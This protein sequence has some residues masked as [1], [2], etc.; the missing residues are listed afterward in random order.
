MADEK[1]PTPEPETAEATLNRQPTH[2]WNM[3][4]G[5]E[6]MR[7]ARQGHTNEFICDYLKGTEAAQIS[8]SALKR[9]YQT[10][11]SLGR[12]SGVMFASSKLMQ[13]IKEGNLTAIIFYLKTKGGFIET[14]GFQ[15]R[16]KDN[17]PEDFDLDFSKATEEELNVLHRYFGQFITDEPALS[18]A[19]GAAKRSARTRPN[20]AGTR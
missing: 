9:H 7:I 2:I 17:E 18:R 19:A 8:V 5:Q 16:D 14:R 4:L 12:T 11:L 6:I 13:K 20:P 15:M 10:E 1:K 3:E